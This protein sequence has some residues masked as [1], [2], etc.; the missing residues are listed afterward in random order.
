MA[1]QS[2]HNA[3]QSQDKERLGY[4]T[5]KPVALLERIIKA[6]TKE[7]DIVLDPFCGCGTTLDAS[8]NLKRKWIGIDIC[9]LSTTLI[10]ERLKNNYKILVKGKD[11]IIDGIPITMEQVKALIEKSDKSKNEGRYQFQYWAIEKV[12]GFAS[13]KKSGDG[14]IDGSIY[15]YKDENKTLGRMILSV[16]S[17][18]KLQA[19]FIRDLIGTM[20][21]NNADMAG[22]IS[23][24]P[25]SQDMLNEAKKSGTFKMKDGLFANVEYPKVQILTAEEILNGKKFNLP[26]SR[27][28]KKT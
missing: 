21:N 22:L 20:E 5:Q 13:T 3:I 2:D 24:A 26:Y 4:P 8:Q 1:L 17:N 10:E 15:F 19:S 11:Y 12:Q 9:M 28:I 25:P 14:G 27:L 6:T 18:K 7:D 16:K 23:Y